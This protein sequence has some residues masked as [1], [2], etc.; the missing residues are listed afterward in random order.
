MRP[1]R[2]DIHELEGVKAVILTG[3]TRCLVYVLVSLTFKLVAVKILLP[4]YS[5]II[6]T[7]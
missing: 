5:I 1:R 3:D 6:G 2:R 4:T 7:V